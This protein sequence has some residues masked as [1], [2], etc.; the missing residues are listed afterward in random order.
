MKKTRYTIFFASSLWAFGCAS[1]PPPDAKPTP[2]EESTKPEN[3]DM[4]S[5]YG[6]VPENKPAATDAQTSPPADAPVNSPATTAPSPPPVAAY[7]LVVNDLIDPPVSPAFDPIATAIRKKDWSQAS[8]AL[9][10]I[11]LA[12]DEKGPFHEK[13]AAHALAGRIAEQLKNT[14]KADAEYEIVL[15]L[16]K[17]PKAIS[18]AIES[19]EGAEDDKRLRQQIAAY[20]VGEAQFYFAEKQGREANAVAIPKYTGSGDKD[21]VLK[22]INEK[23]TAW[24]K[25]KKPKIETAEKEY[26]KILGHQPAPHPRW[27][28]AG[29]TRVGQL[30]SN[31]VNDFRNTPMPKAW[32]SDGKVPGTEL[33]YAELRTE[34]RAKIDEASQPQVDM[35]RQA[36]R[37]CTD[38]GAK[39]RIEN[40]DSKACQTWLTAHPSAK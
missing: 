36:F 2:A 21:D 27:V 3:S 37:T 35:A 31:F 7:K 17:D 12:I 13:V 24:L 6:N 8:A 15:A 22:F 20:A 11:L 25:V 33:T 16:E 19:S 5:V 30:W 32:L 18:T 4:V 10:K 34:Y 9:K 26:A 28:I 40:D 1:A 29:A 38:Y 23:V 14:K 39:F